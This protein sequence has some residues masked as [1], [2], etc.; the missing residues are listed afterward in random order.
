[1]KG[2]SQLKMPEEGLVDI[3]FRLYDGSDIGPF[4]YS[5]ASTIDVLKQRVITDWPKGKTIIPKGV[6]EVKLISSGKILENNKTV[7]QCKMPFGDR[8]IAGG[9]IIMHVVV[10]PSLAKT[11]T[12]KKVDNPP[13]KVVCSCSIL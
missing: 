6:N 9:V 2:E 12:E 4:Q 13:K 3:K 8:E 11:K 7:G 1:M 5:A 10:Q